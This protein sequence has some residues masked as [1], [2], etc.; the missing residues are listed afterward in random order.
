MTPW[1]QNPRR[2]QKPSRADEGPTPR[3]AAAKPAAAPKPTPRDPLDET[4]AP[5]DAA[6]AAPTRPPAPAA[7]KTIPPR[8]AGATQVPPPKAVRRSDPLELTVPEPDADAPIGATGEWQPPATPGGAEPDG[9]EVWGGDAASEDAKPTVAAAKKGTKA[10]VKDKTRQGKDDNTDFETD[11]DIPEALG[12]YQIVKQLG[13]GGMGTVYLARQMSLDRHVALKV[14]NPQWA[15]KPTFLARFTREAY[16]AAQLVHHHIVQIYDIGADLDMPFFS[17]EFV[18][19]QHL[20]EVLRDNGPLDIE[21]AV[22]YVL[23]AAR[24][25]KFAHDQGMVHR[26]IK[27]DNLML[28]DQGLVKVADLGLVKTPGAVAAEDQV[29]TEAPSGEKSETGNPQSEGKTP[30]TPAPRPGSKLSEVSGVTA[31]G[32]AMGTPAFMAPEQGRNAALVDHRADIYSLG[33]TLYVLAHRP[34]PIP[35]QDR[36]RGH[37]QALQ[38][39]HCPARGHRQARA[40]GTLR[41]PH[42]DDGQ[43]ARRPPSGHGRGHHRPGKLPRH[44]A[45]RP[46]HAA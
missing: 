12:G 25:L 41:H 45:D 31:V 27:P 29:G 46:V 21:M 20:G 2:S 28:N 6:P 15:A 37:H 36:H 34:A 14:M 17:M 16:A 38:R 10:D 43:E 30:K 1:R 5:E 40:Q 23:Q 4:V 19:G 33:C 44:P 13:Q 7:K 3:K 11:D 22:G 42:E 8:A 24:G 39:T 18:K 32:V 35:G 9:T 26:D